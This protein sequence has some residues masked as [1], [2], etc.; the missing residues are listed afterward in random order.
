M[1]PSVQRAGSG[2]GLLGSESKLYSPTAVEVGQRPF[3]VKGAR[4]LRLKEP[5]QTQAIRD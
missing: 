3:L 2:A 5:Q 4:S 1:W